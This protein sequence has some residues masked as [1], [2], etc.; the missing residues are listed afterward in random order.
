MTEINEEILEV[1]SRNKMKDK[2]IVME[3]ERGSNDL[4]KI[5]QT[6]RKRV[7][8]LISINTSHQQ[9]MA[10]LIKDNNELK[11][12]N[13]RLAKQIEDYFNAR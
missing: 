13:K 5:I 7:K 2:G 9:L 6:L 11:R 1:I 8:E 4:D 3:D 10:K 12:D